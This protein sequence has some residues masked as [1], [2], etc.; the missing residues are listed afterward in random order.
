M[1]DIVRVCGYTGYTPNIEFCCRSEEKIVVSGETIYGY[2]FSA[3][4]NHIEQDYNCNIDFYQLIDQNQG[5][6]LILQ[7][8][9]NK[10]DFLEISKIIANELKKR[11]LTFNKI[12]WVTDKYRSFLYRLLMNNGRTI[13][14]IKLP[15]VT[16]SIPEDQYIEMMVEGDVGEKHE[17]I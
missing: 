17:S 15:I 4:V 14:C 5:F 9:N 11:R 3:L 12:Y 16:K 10:M 2:E 8:P 1:H 6:S 7:S 13:Q